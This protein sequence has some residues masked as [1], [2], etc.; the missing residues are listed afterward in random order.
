MV[1]EAFEKFNWL[2]LYA[3]TPKAASKFDVYVPLVLNCSTSVA[4][5]GNVGWTSQFEA[6]LQLPL[7]AAVQ[8]NVAARTV[9][10]QLKMT[11]AENPRST[12]PKRV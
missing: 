5:P 6:V 1:P 12:L 9:P 2:R 10:P 8:V 3:P 11:H 7:A 4:V